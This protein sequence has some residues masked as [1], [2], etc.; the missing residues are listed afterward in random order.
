MASLADELAVA[1][2]QLEPVSDSPRLDAEILL[3]HALGI[4]RSSLLARLD[5][6]PGVEGFS[7]LLRRRL[8]FEPIAYILGEWEFF[9]LSLEVCPPVLVPRPETEHLVERVLEF[10]HDTPAK[11]VE[12]GTGTGCVSIAIACNAPTV[13]IIATD[14]RSEN[15]ELTTRNAARHAVQHR[16]E[17]RVGETFEPIRPDDGPIDVICSNPPYVEEG[18]WDTLSPIIRLHED[19]AAL[20]SG[21]DGLDMIRQLISKGRNHLRPGG[22]LAFEIGMGQYEQ[23]RALLE[24]HNYAD[25]DVTRDLA[26]IERIVSAEAPLA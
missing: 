2:A 1:T 13:S 9:S 7:D 21:S 16:I 15:L 11:I 8:S 3:A 10:V 20:L 26:G 25:I 17:C 22:L 6:S 18:K 4:S 24:E 19:K 14:I 23:V 12:I 5:D